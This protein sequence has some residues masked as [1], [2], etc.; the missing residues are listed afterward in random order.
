MGKLILADGL[1][2]TDPNSWIQYLGVP[3]FYRLNSKMNC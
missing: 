3:I 2:I 1:M